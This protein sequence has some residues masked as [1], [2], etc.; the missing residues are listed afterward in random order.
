MWRRWRMSASFS[1]VGDLPAKRSAGSPA[2]SLKK[3]RKVMNSTTRI[4]S[5]V[6]ARRR[7]M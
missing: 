4:T 3:T 5:T 6:Q 2:G 7:A 1:G